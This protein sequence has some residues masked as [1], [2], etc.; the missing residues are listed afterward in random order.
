MH[1]DAERI[2]RDAPGGSAC[3]AADCGA[4]RQEEEIKS[5]WFKFGHAS[6]H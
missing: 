5:A 6:F 3:E 1:P 2:S 4:L